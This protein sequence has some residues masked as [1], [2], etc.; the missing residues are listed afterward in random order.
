MW[1]GSSN[2]ETKLGTYEWILLLMLGLTHY[3]KIRLNY[4]DN[5]RMSHRGLIHL[6][7]SFVPLTLYSWC[8]YIGSLRLIHSYAK[9]NLK[10][11]IDLRLG[12]T[13]SPL[14]L[15]ANQTQF[16]FLPFCHASCPLELGGCGWKSTPSKWDIPSRLRYVTIVYK[17][18]VSGTCRVLGWRT[19]A[20]K[21]NKVV[22][23]G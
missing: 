8:V 5:E 2:I 14:S 1:G 6:E 23:L 20:F 3:W 7:E 19:F 16:L 12:N 9:L 4:D 22:T 21:C 15:C 11:K 18:D 10:Q 17:P 13:R